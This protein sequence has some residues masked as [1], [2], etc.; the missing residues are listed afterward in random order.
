VLLD[1]LKRMDILL[2]H[3]LLASPE[4]SLADS[5]SEAGSEAGEASAAPLMDPRNPNMP[6]LDDSMMFFSRGAL[7]FNTGM[8]LKMA[9]TRWV[10]WG[11][12][13]WGVGVVGVGGW[14]VGGAVWVWWGGV[15]VWW[16]LKGWRGVVQNALQAQNLT[17]PWGQISWL[18]PLP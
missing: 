5:F 9:C 13:G 8:N 6:V 18:R 10:W 14:G 15:G 16:G 4:G 2:F 3:Y 12:C 17:Y 7:T 1:L 11:G